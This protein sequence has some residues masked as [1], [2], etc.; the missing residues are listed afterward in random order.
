MYELRETEADVKEFAVAVTV[1]DVEVSMLRPPDVVETVIADEGRV[2]GGFRTLR[3]EIVREIVD[4]AAIDVDE[5]KDTVTICVEADA[6][7]VYPELAE[8][9]RVQVEST[10]S[11][12]AVGNSISTWLVLESAFSVMNVT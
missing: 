1:A 10:T 5:K 3:F 6:V 9:G 2:E 7:H 12:E 11:N 8:E 4:P